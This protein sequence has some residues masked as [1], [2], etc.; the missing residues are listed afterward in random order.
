MLR[1]MKA[2]RCIM[3]VL[4]A[5]QSGSL[6]QQLCRQL[7]DSLR[8]YWTASEL[9]RAERCKQ[10][11]ELRRLRSLTCDGCCITGDRAP[12]LMHERTVL[13]LCMECY[14]RAEDLL[15]DELGGMPCPSCGGLCSFWELWHNY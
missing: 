4:Q 9:A 8:Q 2:D 11:A 13:L 6:P 3:A 15:E 7:V 14:S 12:L 5:L 10:E 1:I